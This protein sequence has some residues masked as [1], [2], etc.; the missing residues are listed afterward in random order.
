MVN[1]NLGK[2][3]VMNWVGRFSRRRDGARRAEMEAYGDVL[4]GSSVW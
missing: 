4:G 3:T 1:V 2:C